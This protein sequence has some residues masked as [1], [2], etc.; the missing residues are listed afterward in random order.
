MKR[1]CLGLAV[2]ASMAVSIAA[3]Y[4]SYEIQAEYRRNIAN[5]IPDNRLYCPKVEIP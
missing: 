3:A 5:G 4:K 1:F 2:S